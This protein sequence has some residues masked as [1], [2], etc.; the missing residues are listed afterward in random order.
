MQ[1]YELPQGLSDLEPWPFT[2]PESGYV[3]LSGSPEA[4]GR[5]DAG[6]PGHTTR[7]GLWRCTKGVF[8]CTEQ[9]DELMTLLTGRCRVADLTTGVSLDLGPT[10]TAF[11][12]DGSRVRW[13]ILE[14]VVKVFF[15]HNERGY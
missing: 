10:D 2:A 8:E 13:E 12:K 6:G 11:L 1:Q 9:G 14:D 5:L 15:A 7:R 3:I 4:S